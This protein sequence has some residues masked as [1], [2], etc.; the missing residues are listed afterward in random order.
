[1]ELNELIS[2]TGHTLSFYSSHQMLDNNNKK[3]SRER[4]LVRLWRS[5]WS[6]IIATGWT[7][8]QEFCALVSLIVPDNSSLLFLTRVIILDFCYGM[9]TKADE[10]T[11]SIFS[12]QAVSW[13]SLP[14][15]TTKCSQ[16]VTIHSGYLPVNTLLF[17]HRFFFSKLWIE[18]HTCHL[19]SES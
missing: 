3:W 4:I 11:N 15:I 14:V 8:Y 16:L 13:V 17:F 10:M 7:W 9:K 6:V 18:W 1:M 5:R 19:V 12:V 2:I